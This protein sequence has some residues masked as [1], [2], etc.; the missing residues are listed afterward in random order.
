M[1]TVSSPASL[2]LRLRGGVMLVVAEVSPGRSI[3]WWR[4]RDG[5]VVRRALPALC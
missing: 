4:T 1:H 2:R 5:Q 3:A